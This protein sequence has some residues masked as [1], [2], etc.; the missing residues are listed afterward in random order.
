[1]RQA[2]SGIRERISR[3]TLIPSPSGRRTSRIATSGRRAG[4]RARAD[5]AV[6][7]SPITRISG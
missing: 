5:A 6:A 3:Q 4:M 2:T 7:A 1:M